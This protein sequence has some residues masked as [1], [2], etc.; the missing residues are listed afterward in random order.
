MA[1]SIGMELNL[2]VGKTNHMHV[3]SNFIPSTFYNCIKIK[4]YVPTVIEVSF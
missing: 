1:R 4:L 3:S 2:A